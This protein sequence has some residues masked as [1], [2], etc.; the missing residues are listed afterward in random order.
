MKRRTIVRAGTTIVAS[1]LTAPWLWH[2]PAHAA[3]L[4]LL[5]PG[6]LSSA[7]EGTYPPFSL[8]NASGELDGL[9]MRTM[10]EI[11][12]RLGLTYNPV[13]IKWESMLVGLLSDQYDIVGNAMGISAE[14]QKKV[15]FCDAWIESGARLLVHKDSPIQSNAEVKGKTIGAIS[16]S[17]FIPM[18][19][20]LGGTVKLYKADVEAMQDCVNGRVDSIIL[21]SIAAAYAIKKSKLPLR[22][23]PELIEPYQL[24][25]A[26]KQGKPNLVRAI[27]AARAEMVAD[28]T[29][30]KLVEPLVGYDPS[31]KDPIKSIL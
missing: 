9:E 10:G 12:K 24:G 16:A 8:R 30:A 1:A 7:T 14:R 15:T 21:D 23:T 4:E 29:F 26:V 25:W 22:W 27:N 31:P 13:V 18:A 19:E 6:T 17:T 20:R 11:C 2:R 5:A 3:D 28:G